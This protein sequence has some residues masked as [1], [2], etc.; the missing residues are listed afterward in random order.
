LLVGCNR[1]EQP[2]IPQSPNGTFVVEATTKDG[3]LIL[4]VFSKNKLTHTIETKASIYQKFALGW[5]NKEQVLI[6]YSSDI[7]VRAWTSTNGFKPELNTRKYTA[8][9][10]WL[11]QNKYGKSS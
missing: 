10:N 8:Y 3:L 1:I 5:H 9:A 2:L 4:N 11:Y 7:G 6:L